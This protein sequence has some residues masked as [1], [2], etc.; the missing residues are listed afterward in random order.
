MKSLSKADGIN[1]F[2]ARLRK[3]IYRHFIREG[4]N[5]GPTSVRVSPG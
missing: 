2:D 1:S 3:F 5:M 4:L